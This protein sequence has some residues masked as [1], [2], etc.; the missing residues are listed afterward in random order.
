MKYVS[1]YFITWYDSGIIELMLNTKIKW[2]Y[3]YKISN[4]SY[5]IAKNQVESIGELEQC[6]LKI[7]LEALGLKEGVDYTSSHYQEKDEIV[8]YFIP[9]NLVTQE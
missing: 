6:T 9:L 7:P 8:Y 3:Y 5:V 2:L 4:E 1:S